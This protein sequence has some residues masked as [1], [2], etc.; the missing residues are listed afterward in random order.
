MKIVLVGPKGAGKS[1]VGRELSSR[2]GLEAIETDREI[3]LRYAAESGESLSCRE[4]CRRLGR[5][6]FQ[7]LE[8]QTVAGLAGRDWRLIICGGST[9]LDPGSRQVLREN[10]FIIYLTAP[11]QVLWDRA[12]RNGLPPWLEGEDGREI[13]AR[14]VALREEVYRPFADVELES[15]A[16]TPAEIAA[17]ARE[18]IGREIA[19][20]CRA[21]NTYGEIIRVTTFGESHGPAI[22]AV[23]EGIRPGIEISATD[24][25]AQLDRRRPGQSRVTTQRNEADEVQI[26]SGIFAGKTTGAPIALLIRNQD[27]DASKYEALKDVFRP[28]HA[29]F[30][31]YKKYGIRDHRG[32]GRASGRETAA[33]V[34]CG[35][36][37]MKILSS[38]GI[39]IV[40]H[41]VEIAG[42]RAE[43]CDFAIIEKNPVRC[44]DPEAA[45]KMET[46][47]L[48]ARQEQDSVGGIIQL[49]IHGA[50]AGLGDP[51]F[52]KLDARL[53][54]AIMTV[55]AVKG[56]E[57]GGG[58]ALCRQRGSQANDPLQDGKFLSNNAGGILGGIS[59]GQP[60][61]LR[62]A[63]KPTSSIARP[64]QTIDK[65]GNNREIK[66]EGR[67][68]PCIVPRA[69]PVIEHM[70]ALA[71]LDAWEVQE[72]L[73]PEWRPG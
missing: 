9:F 60:I 66:I 69:V 53:T 46:E 30:T 23:L 55:G 58:F 43:T 70:T 47:V 4:I 13:F 21:A 10:A 68:D 54:A 19:T 8:R 22:G 41:A 62:V 17:Q 36:V 24:I 40:A 31:F 18:A 29:D 1:E 37:A 64:Q 25:Q 49:E 42:I 3:E 65:Q 45:K 61:V 26:L 32:G 67:H 50:P 73:R 7:E 39:R 35:A 33:R 5:E 57:V 59:T 16:A 63:V 15:S 51:V 20:R 34:A 14:D 38:R 52:G 6:K 56:V 28:G 11:E 12:T 44:A 27:Q 2:L 71:L 72:R 48:K